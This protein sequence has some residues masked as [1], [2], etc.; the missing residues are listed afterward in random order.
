MAEK[1]EPIPYHEGFYGAVHTLYEPTRVSFTYLQE[2]ELGAQP[3]RMDMLLIKQNQKERLEDPIGRFFRTYN[4]L[5][6]K[7]PEDGLSI[8]DFCKAQGYAL[9]YKSLGKRV[10]EIPLG[11]LTVSI[12]RHIYPRELLSTLSR[13][14]F[15]V[16]E[17]TTG[18]YTVTGPLCIPTQI[19]VTARLPQGT[20]LALKILS[21][22]AEKTDILEFLESL[23]TTHDP[24]ILHYSHAVLEVSISANQALYQTLREENSMSGVEE[25]FKDKFDQKWEQG[26]EEGGILSSA[27]Y[28]KKGLISIAEAAK[29][30]GMSASQF[31]SRAAEL[32][33]PVV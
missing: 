9:I 27:Q 29:T 24:S 22:H 14:G 1:M 10:N 8:D 19:V 28:V 25:L 21:K 30:L 16:S 7:P 13:E 3:L 20:Y 32:G 33:C 11:D 31:T 23:R 15:T 4:V 5:E 17:Y 6:Y 12:F 18:I 26:R 2:Y